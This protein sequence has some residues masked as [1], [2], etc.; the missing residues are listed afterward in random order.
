VTALACAQGSMFVAGMIFA[1]SLGALFGA[2][3]F[4]AAER[5]CKPTTKKGRSGEWI[6]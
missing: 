2:A 1:V 4:Y 5:M 6:A 3:L